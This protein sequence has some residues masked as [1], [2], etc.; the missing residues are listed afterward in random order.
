MS[1]R[2]GEEYTGPWGAGAYTIVYNILENK[3]TFM[4]TGNDAHFTRN[5]ALCAL[6]SHLGFA[7]PI[8]AGAT[9]CSVFM[10]IIMSCDSLIK[11]MGKCAV[12]ISPVYSVFIFLS[13]KFNTMKPS[14][15]LL[16]E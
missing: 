1:W 2:Q 11:S 14:D 3:K 8:C 10:T 4:V 6:V 9:A 5:R 7:A 12:R 15:K 16:K 13:K